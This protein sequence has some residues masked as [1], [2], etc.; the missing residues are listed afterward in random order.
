VT[1]EGQQLSAAK[2]PVKL[3]ILLMDANSE[4]RALRTKIMALH[5][6]EVVGAADLA[7][8]GSVWHRD[9][10]DMVLIDI[11]RDYRGCLAWRNEIKKEKPEQVVAFLVGKPQYVDL[12][13]REDSYLAEKSSMEWGDSLR[14][15]VRQSCES[16]PQR[17]GLAEAIWRITAAKKIN[18]AATISTKAKSIEPALDIFVGGKPETNGFSSASRNTEPAF[19]SAAEELGLPVPTNQ[20]ENQ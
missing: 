2:A 11:R 9:R 17:N 5:G 13:P 6:V 16:L 3:C 10:Y 4:R 12:A 14:Q 19:S 20:T 1:N 18:G 8:A 7:E 15:E